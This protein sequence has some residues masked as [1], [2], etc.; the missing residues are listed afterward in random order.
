MIVN[1]CTFHSGFNAKD[2]VILETFYRNLERNKKTC[3]L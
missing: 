2:V 3:F 1:I